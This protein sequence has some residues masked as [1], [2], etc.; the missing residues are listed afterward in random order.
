VSILTQKNRTLPE[1]RSNETGAPPGTHP[2]LDRYL[3][4][5]LP[6]RVLNIV[7]LLCMTLSKALLK[8]SCG[9][10][11]SCCVHPLYFF[12]LGLSNQ[13]TTAFIATRFLQHS[14]PEKW[15]LA[16]SS[17]SAVAEACLLSVTCYFIPKLR[18]IFNMCIAIL[19]CTLLLPSRCERD[20]TWCD[21]MASASCAHAQHFYAL[22]AQMRPLSKS[23]RQLDF[24]VLL[25]HCSAVPLFRTM[26]ASI[27]SQANT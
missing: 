17:K 26:A 14:S 5:S 4:A 7:K 6:S 3:I 25:E 11:S 18:V 10:C 16:N 2:T 21:S 19:L 9:C 23:C 27:L 12:A 15:L 24:C 8:V 13:R 22:A 1:H 20:F